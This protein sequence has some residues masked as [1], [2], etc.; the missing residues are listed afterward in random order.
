MDDAIVIR[1][2]EPRDREALGRLGAALMRTHF[3]FDERRFLNPGQDPERGYGRFLASQSEGHDVIVLVAE[4]DGEVVG[5][6]FAGIEPRSW[7]ELRDTAGFIHDVS[8][9]ED[10]RGEGIAA[11]LIEAAA[12]WLEARGMPR[13][14]LW[15]A[16]QNEAAQHLF[17]RLGF[18]RTMIEMTREADTASAR[19]TRDEGDDA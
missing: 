8:V 19:R 16:E 1:R 6:V 18:R 15:T 12:E 3:A 14:M 5:Y 9:A 7:K 11:R 10:A 4:R 2:A 17:E 13:V